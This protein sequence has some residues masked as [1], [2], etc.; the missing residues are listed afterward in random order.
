MTPNVHTADDDHQLVPPTHP[1][2]GLI[3]VDRGRLSG[4]PCFDQTRV[5]IKS[6]WDYLEG[7]E[8][9]SE[10]LEDFEGV[11]AEQAH[12]VLRLALQALLETLPK[13]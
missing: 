11:T 10:F 4:V 12:G 1:A 13:P 6:L 9:L 5:P 7:G 2:A 8:P 3:W